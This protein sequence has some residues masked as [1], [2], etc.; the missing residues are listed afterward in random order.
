[1]LVEYEEISGKLL[2]YGRG[3]TPSE[4]KP[5]I[6]PK[7]NTITI[8][9]IK[10][11]WNREEVIKLCTNAFEAGDKFRLYLDKNATNIANENIPSS[12]VSFCF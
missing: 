1:M 3:F 6:N 11:S 10:D 7:D 8:T 5:K 9:K 4:I 2:S 12:D